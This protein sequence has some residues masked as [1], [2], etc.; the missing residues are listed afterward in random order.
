MSKLYNLNTIKE[1]SDNDPEFVKSMVDIFITEIPQDLE[2]L[3]VGVVEDDRERV[4]EYA[5]KMKPTVD[6][7][8][9]GCYQDILVMEA[10][11]KSDDPMDINEH[12]MRVQENLQATVQQLREDF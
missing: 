5:H 11:G 6:M 12:F 3:A 7:F 1:L 8:A 10:W 2:N 9:L 4:H